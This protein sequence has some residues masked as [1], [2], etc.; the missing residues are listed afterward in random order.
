MKPTKTVCLTAALAASLAAPLAAAQAAEAPPAVMGAAPSPS[1][2]RLHVDAEIDPAG[3]LL[4]GYSLHLGVGWRHLRVDLGAYAMR[5]PQAVH[6]HDDLDVSFDGYG[7]K[8]QYFFRPEQTGGFVGVD[9]GVIRPTVR[10]S[11]T[12]LSERHTELGVGVNFGWRFT[13]AE[14]FYATPWLGIGYGLDPHTVTVGGSTYE[15]SHLSVFPAVHFGY[16]FQ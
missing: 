12:Q 9:A 16:R 2:S 4:D 13:F 11:G 6:G 3:Y 10:K 8:L 7:V 1:P 14:R 5:L 15:G